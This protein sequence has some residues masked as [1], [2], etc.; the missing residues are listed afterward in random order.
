MSADDSRTTRRAFFV[1]GSATLGA[2]VAAAAGAGALGSQP[3][4]PPAQASQPSGHA[5][6]AAECTAILKVHQAFIADVE[7]GR[8]PAAAE[9]HRAY[10]SNARQVGD[11]LVLSE[12]GT[13]AEGYWHVDVKLGT[14]L[15]GDST[16][17]QMARLQGMLAEV[18]WESG[19]IE[20]RYEKRA[21]QWQI[22]ALH[23]RS[24]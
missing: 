10:R 16:A 5:R 22:S 12:D 13:R 21:G 11:Q 3:A 9:T 8:T 18:R 6:D 1:K 7:D 24:A 14:P 17:A 20:A 4:S 2:G 15:E 19:V 23:Y